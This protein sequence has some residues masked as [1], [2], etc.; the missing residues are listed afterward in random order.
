MRPIRQACSCVSSSRYS[1]ASASR[2]STSRRDWSRSR[3][4]SATLSSSCAFCSRSRSWKLLDV[5]QV[6]HPQ[7][8]LDAIQRLGQEIARAHREGTSPR[9]IRGISSQ[10]QERHA[11]PVI[12]QR[13][14]PVHQLE[15][16]HPR[17]VEI[18]QH[19]IG[20]KLDEHPRNPRRIRSDI[21]A[22]VTLPLEDS[23][24]QQQIRLLV[25]HRED[26]ELLEPL[27]VSLHRSSP[28]ASPMIV[29]I[30]AR[31]FL[32]AALVAPG[33][34][35]TLAHTTPPRAISSRQ[36]AARTSATAPDP[37][38]KRPRIQPASATSRHASSG[39]PVTSG[40]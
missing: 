12:G 5:Q 21:H 24:H 36:A 18:E 7:Q 14:K 20:S 26:P 2:S 27:L 1:A 28:S 9:L 34:L 19:Q 38:N 23:P 31:N 6:A 37:R 32:S 16:I 30:A 22:R 8:Q 17:H 35:S 40:R 3:V 4:R 13:P 10:H 11:A 39:Q 25:V 29:A 33:V 15:P